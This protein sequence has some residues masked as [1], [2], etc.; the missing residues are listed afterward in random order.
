MI[1]T[2]ELLLS[3]MKSQVGFTK[4]QAKLLGVPMPLENGWKERIIGQ[5]FPIETIK[6]FLAVNG[7]TL[8][9]KPVAS[10]T[11]AEK[12]FHGLYE[13]TCAEAGTDPAEIND[14]LMKFNQYGWELVCATEQLLY[15]K[16][17]TK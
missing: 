2:K 17:L 3:G 8:N 1:L 13:N 16:R 10:N 14:T 9:K 12:P 6:S 4:V 5:Y 7:K 15:F 11:T